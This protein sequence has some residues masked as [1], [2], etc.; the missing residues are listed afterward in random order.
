MAL[1]N[2]LRSKG[3][4][5]GKAAEMFNVGELRQS[6]LMNTYG[7]GS[8]VDFVDNTV[9]I[10]GVDEWAD[11]EELRLYNENLQQLTGAQ[12]FLQ[13]KPAEN[14]GV[15]KKS[16]DIPSYTFPDILYCPN[17]NG[18]FPSKK[19]KQVKGVFK[20]V[21][22]SNTLVASR[23]VMVCNN[24]HMTDFPYDWWVHRGEQCPSKKKRLD[25][26]CIM[27]IKGRI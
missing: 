23:F 24:G 1:F 26:R 12:Y 14:I 13:P 10:A 3:N 8:I 27:W 2:K 7:V 22:C 20:C 16:N 21:N 17:C 18:L 4:A 19:A 25:W 6:Q 15:W 5:A 9:I 11:E